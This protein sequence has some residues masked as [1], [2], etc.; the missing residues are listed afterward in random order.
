M[1]TTAASWFEDESSEPQKKRET[2]AEEEMRRVGT[3]FMAATV[4][5]PFARGRAVTRAT[6]WAVPALLLGAAAAIIFSRLDFRPTAVSSGIVD[7]AIAIAAL[8][9]AVVAVVSGLRTVQHV[10]AAVWPGPLGIQAD[11]E[12]LQLFLGPFGMRGYRVVELDVRYPFEMEDEDG[13]GFEQFLPEVEQMARMLPRIIHRGT[14]VP[15]NR[16]I[17]RFAAGDEAAIASGLLPVIQHWRSE[18]V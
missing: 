2:V 15:I 6:L 8:P 4:F 14:K 7:Y 16:T 18:K 11:R 3:D 9:L 1:S 13:G 17:L 5:I 12:Y 10:L